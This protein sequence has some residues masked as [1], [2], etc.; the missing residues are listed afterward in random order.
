M[1]S[2]SYRNVCN[3]EAVIY[4]IIPR[5]ETKALL[6]PHGWGWFFINRCLNGRDSLGNPGVFFQEK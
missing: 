6:C 2:V 4:A 5:V 1:Q 3:A